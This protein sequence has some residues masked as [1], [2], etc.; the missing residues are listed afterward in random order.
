M[1]LKYAILYVL[2]LPVGIALTAITLARMYNGRISLPRWAKMILI[3][4]MILSQL[5][6]VAAMLPPSVYQAVEDTF[7][8][9]STHPVTGIDPS[10]SAVVPDQ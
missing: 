7:V 1:T 3:I 2:L 8:Q 6:L 9:K 4:G 10:Q 5:I